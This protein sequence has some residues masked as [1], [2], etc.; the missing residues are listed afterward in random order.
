MPNTK[1]EELREL[2]ENYGIV[3]ECDIMNKCGFVWMQTE[4]M[5]QSAIENL[6]NTTFKGHPIVVEPGRIK[7]RGQKRPNDGGQG[8]RGGFQRSGPPQGRSQGP[9]RGNNGGG[10][11]GP[12]RRGRDAPMRRNNPYG[13]RDF[14]RRNDNNGPL[15]PPPSFGAGF[16]D[17]NFGFS[18]QDRR[19]FALP[20]QYDNNGPQ[21]RSGGFRGGAPSG[22]GF[23]QGGFGGNNRNNDSRQGGQGFNRGGFNSPGGGPKPNF[24]R[25]R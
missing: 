20:N 5:A 16:D 1:P 11:G 21:Q 14:G 6:K 24:N 13:S 8:S 23:R 17:N 25:G 22:S 19:G 9:N 2:F 18:N 4:E 3:T 15:Q 7:D 12:M 10:G